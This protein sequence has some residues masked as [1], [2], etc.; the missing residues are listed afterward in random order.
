MF[1]SEMLHPSRL[2]RMLVSVLLQEGDHAAVVLRAS[3]GAILAVVTS[4][5]YLLCFRHTK[6]LLRH[7]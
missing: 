4:A 7:T 1:W 6:K 2:Q 5:G 3:P